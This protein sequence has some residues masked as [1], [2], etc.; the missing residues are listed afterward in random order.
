MPFGSVRVAPLTGPSVAA[1]ATEILKYEWVALARVGSASGEGTGAGRPG[2]T[3][4]PTHWPVESSRN[5]WCEPGEQPARKMAAHVR[6]HPRRSARRGPATGLTGPF[7]PLRLHER[8][9][10]EH[11]LSKFRGARAE[12]RRSLYLSCAHDHGR[13]PRQARTGPLGR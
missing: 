2:P 3:P 12:S 7:T 6:R 9:K 4:V 1:S 8:P 13:Q 10:A 5:A 11:D